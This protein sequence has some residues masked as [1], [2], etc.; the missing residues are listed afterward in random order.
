MLE[1][2]PGWTIDVERGPDWLI[3]RLH[4]PPAEAASSIDLTS[5]LWALLRQHFTYRLVLEMD[6]LQQLDDRMVGQILDL[7]DRLEDHH[8]MLRLCGLSDINLRALRGRRSGCTPHYR[9]RAAA[10]HG[11]TRLKPR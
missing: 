2:A 7:R 11:A 1:I 9:D 4:A 6:Q 3:C 5:A 10:L 8:G